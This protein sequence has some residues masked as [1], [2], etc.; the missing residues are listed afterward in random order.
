MD[1]RHDI[2]PPSEPPPARG[3]EPLA[4]LRHSLRTSGIEQIDAAISRLTAELETAELSVLDAAMVAGRLR[5]LRAA[6]WL[7]QRL[8]SPPQGRDASRMPSALLKPAGSSIG[9]STEQR[10]TQE[11]FTGERFPAASPA[12]LN[13]PD[14]GSEVVTLSYPPPPNRSSRRLQTALFDAV[15]AQLQFSL[16]NLADTPLE[17]DILKE[18]KKRELLILV[19]RQV[20]NLLADLQFSQV[21]AAQLADQQAAILQ[22]LWQAVL[23]EFIGK[24]Y[25][26]QL[27]GRSVAVVETALGDRAIVQAAILDK[28]PLV[29]DLLTHLLFQTPLTID[30]AT[31]RSGTVEAMQRG[32]L[33]LQN[34]IIQ[35]ANAV[36]QPLLNRFGDISAIKPLYDQ[37]LLSSRE[38]E[39]FR[40]DLS[41]KYRLGRYFLEP[42]AIFESRYC[43]WTIA[44]TGICQ[45]SIYFPRNQEL[46]QLAGI[47]FAVTLA[48]ELRDAIAPRLRTV[49]G[50]FGSG[51]VYVLTEI[52]GRGIGLIGRGVMKGIG[53]KARE[54]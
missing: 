1:D 48:L 5:E 18:D 33:L 15:A 34:L 8:L 49:T 32:E 17:I 21:T 50:F 11:R 6:R 19:L 27:E 24:Y 28:I 38:I 40:N 25:T 3:S 13:A 2:P 7:V 31:Y 44:E 45:Q 53:K 26:V 23:T 54:G 47:P 42:T 20:E 39:R 35:M 36:M 16:R 41:W 12:P 30:D 22:D 43:L 10:F 37:R 29:T 46:D 9:S 4:A 52:I 51:V 14:S